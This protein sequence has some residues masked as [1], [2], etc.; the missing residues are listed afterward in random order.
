[1]RASMSAKKGFGA[2]S[3]MAM[4]YAFVGHL[5]NAENIAAVIELLVSITL[6]TLPEFWQAG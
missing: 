3:P 1:M 6:S 2:G 4:R 5:R